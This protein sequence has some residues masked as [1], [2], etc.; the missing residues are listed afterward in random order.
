MKG[1]RFVIQEHSTA[2][3]V[4]WDLMLEQAD[5]LVTFRLEAAPEAALRRAIRARKIRD[6]P[7]KFLTYEGMVQNGT[8]RVRIVDRGTCRLDIR[9]DDLFAL[10]LDGMI[11]KGDF[12]L[13]RIKNATWRFASASEGS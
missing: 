11:L 6:H 13:S 12:I 4:H 2:D 1:N 5:I 7:I 8:G 9:D 3:G 10:E